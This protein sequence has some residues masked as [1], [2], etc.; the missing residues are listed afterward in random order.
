M[1]QVFVVEDEPSL[2]F[3]YE[4]IITLNGFKLVGIAEDGEEAV[5]KY[6]TF[7]E[8]PKVI[9]MDHRMPKK[10]GIEASKIILQMDDKVKIIFI[11]ADNSIKEEALSIG[12]FSFW[13]K[14]FTINQIVNEIN[15]AIECY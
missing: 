6:K 14:L 12:V 1:E 10:N 15:R 11:S 9:L 2:Q 4:Q 13:D 8:K 7:S 3:F 5:E